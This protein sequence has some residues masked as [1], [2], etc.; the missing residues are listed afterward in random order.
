LGLAAE[1]WF[2]HKPKRLR[3][4]MEQSYLALL[5]IEA[6]SRSF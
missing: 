1:L 4:L 5:P 2:I 6:P 3:K